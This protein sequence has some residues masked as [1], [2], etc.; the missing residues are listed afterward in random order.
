VEDVVEMHESGVQIFRQL[1]ELVE[2]VQVALV[3]GGGDAR[4]QPYVIAVFDAF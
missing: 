3:Q 1:D 4:V 2:F